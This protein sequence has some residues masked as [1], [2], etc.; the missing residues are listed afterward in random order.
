MA[1]PEPAGPVPHAKPKPRAG[2]TLGAQVGKVQIGH[3]KEMFWE[4]ASVDQHGT[5][6]IQRRKA[7]NKRPGLMGF[8]RFHWNPR[9]AIRARVP[10]TA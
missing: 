8:A 3:A 7:S 9:A 1:T 2:Q 4:I 6:I 5:P 10:S